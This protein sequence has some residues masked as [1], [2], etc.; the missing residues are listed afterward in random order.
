MSYLN[1]INKNTT[2]LACLDFYRNNYYFN[3]LPDFKVNNNTYKYFGY[4][5]KRNKNQIPNY[6][7][8]F[9]TIRGTPEV[10]RKNEYYGFD[11]YKEFKDL[12]IINYFT[13]E[14]IISNFGFIIFSMSQNKDIFNYR[15]KYDSRLDNDYYNECFQYLMKILSLK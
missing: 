14:Q 2:L 10:I 12:K 7:L 1:K 4:N 5:L 6:Y 3:R 8:N 9:D 11:R 15:N 13:D